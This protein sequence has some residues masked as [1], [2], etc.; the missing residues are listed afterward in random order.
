MHRMGSRHDLHYTFRAYGVRGFDCLIDCWSKGDGSD[1]F[2]SDFDFDLVLFMI[3]TMAF[4]IETL[5]L[6]RVK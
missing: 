4:G 6:C 1:L 2:F 3:H 5:L